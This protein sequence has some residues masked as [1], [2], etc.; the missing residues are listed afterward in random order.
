MPIANSDFAFKSWNIESALLK[1]L[2]EALF[3]NQLMRSKDLLLWNTSLKSE[4]NTISL[5]KEV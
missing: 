5:G 3:I 1:S 4:F 2:L